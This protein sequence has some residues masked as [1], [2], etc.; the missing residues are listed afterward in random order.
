MGRRR[1]EGSTIIAEGS[2]NCLHCTVC[3]HGLMFVPVTALEGP[4]NHSAKGREARH[5]KTG[6]RTGR[7]SSLLDYTFT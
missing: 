2:G 3:V 1:C 6:Q 5:A 4:F 7:G